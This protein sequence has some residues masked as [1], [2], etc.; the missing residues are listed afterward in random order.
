MPP[1]RRY[2]PFLLLIAVQVVLAAVVPSRPGA[3]AQLGAPLAAE[4]GGFSPETGV[5]GAAPGAAP[6]TSGAPAAAI[7]G[8]P[9]GAAGK[10]GAAASA[11]SGSAGQ[12][13]AAAKAGERSQPVN[14]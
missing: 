1:M 13:A 4:T 11:G 5:A 2:A 12:Q 10:P 9:A 7:P 6:G 14:G 8:A 3:Q